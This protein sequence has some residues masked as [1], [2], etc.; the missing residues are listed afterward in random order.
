MVAL[1][2]AKTQINPVILIRK[3]SISIEEKQGFGGNY[4]GFA[5]RFFGF[6]RIYCIVNGCESKTSIDPNLLK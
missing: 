2:K 3:I 1:G 4:F 6:V 5:L